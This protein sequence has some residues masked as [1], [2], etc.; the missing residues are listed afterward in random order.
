[1]ITVRAAHAVDMAEIGRIYVL[2]HWSAYRDDVPHHYL[3][4]MDSDVEAQ[5]FANDL[6]KPGGI[7]LVAVNRV[8]RVVGFVYGGMTNPQQAGLA[9]LFVDRSYR[10]KG[11]AQELLIHFAQG[12]YP[13][14]AQLIRGPVAKCN[15]RSR[16][17]CIKTGATEVDDGVHFPAFDHVAGKVPIDLDAVYEDWHDVAG[18]ALGHLPGAA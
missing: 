14:G 12:V 2:G 5:E 11:V 4:A 10:G 15:V 7:F 1:M 9:E 3:L 16:A 18:L 13:L 8:G 17:F 6:N